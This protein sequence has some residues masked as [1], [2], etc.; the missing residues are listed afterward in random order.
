VSSAIG[1]GSSESSPTGVPLGTVTGLLGANDVGKTRSLV[2][3]Y[4]VMTGLAAVQGK[5]ARP[6]RSAPLKNAARAVF[7]EL[8]DAEF[9]SLLCDGPQRDTGNPPA[10][11]DELAAACSAVDPKLAI[12]RVLLSRPNPANPAAWELVADVLSAS[13]TVMVFPPTLAA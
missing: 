9:G 6:G 7:L 10:D 4:D 3:L 11:L 13:R 2:A 8:D 1:Y 5:K 12:R